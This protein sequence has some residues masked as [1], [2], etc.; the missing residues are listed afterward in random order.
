M[1]FG[2]QKHTVVSYCKTTI[3][4]IYYGFDLEIWIFTY[5]WYIDVTT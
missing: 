4:T 5:N 1:Y 3:V 2:E